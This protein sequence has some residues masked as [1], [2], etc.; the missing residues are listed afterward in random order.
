[1]VVSSVHCIAS[2]Q[3]ADENLQDMVSKYLAESNN[4]KKEEKEEE[5]QHEMLR[6]I[7]EENII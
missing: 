6:R 4:N 2:N 3:I 7:I 1:M 5:T